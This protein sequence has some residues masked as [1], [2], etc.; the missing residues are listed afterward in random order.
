MKRTRGGYDLLH[1]SPFAPEDWGQGEGPK[2]LSWVCEAHGLDS[3]Q[4]G[5]ERDVGWRFYET[6]CDVL[7]LGLELPISRCRLITKT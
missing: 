5:E 7:V 6:F 4:D 1:T 2:L 3:K